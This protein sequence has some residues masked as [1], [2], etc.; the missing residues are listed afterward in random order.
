MYLDCC[1]S[2]K[3]KEN[4]DGRRTETCSKGLVILLDYNRADGKRSSELFPIQYLVL[5]VSF[6][7]FFFGNL[8]LFLRE[9]IFMLQKCGCK[10]Q[11]NKEK[12]RGK[13]DID[14]KYFP[15]LLSLSKGENRSLLCNTLLPLIYWSPKERSRVQSNLHLLLLSDMKLMGRIIVPNSSIQ[16]VFH[17]LITCFFT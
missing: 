15:F 2:T 6:F 13:Y 16:T 1:Y 9:E 14:T 4:D 10:W 12:L 11:G 5:F 8:N 3:L 17:K 7:F